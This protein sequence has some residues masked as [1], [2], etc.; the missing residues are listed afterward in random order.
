M[1]TDL[2]DAAV[3][4]ARVRPRLFGIAYRML[5]SVQ[6]A[7]D[8]VQDVWLKW[9]PYD[10]GTVREPAAFLATMTTRLAINASQTARARRET[11]VGPWLPEPVDTSAD[12]TLGAERGE[13]LELAMLVLLEKLSPTQRAA[14]ILREAFDYPYDQIAEIVQLSEA[15]VRQ[16]VSRSRKRLADERRETVS[17]SE[18]RKLLAA[19]MEAAQEGNL[20]TLVELLAADAVSYSDGGGIVRATKVELFGAEVIAKVTV[21]YAGNFWTGASLSFAEFNGGWSAVV[22]RDGEVFMVVSIS[23]S[24]AGID[25]IQWLLNPEKLTGFSSPN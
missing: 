6:E 25:Q 17:T 5:S 14:Y 3:D 18:Q 11:Y 16:L 1:T 21:G 13:A 10:R 2:D 24:S 12:P 7:E 23:A 8:L 4:F 20:A 22:A 15:N 19:F 9:Q